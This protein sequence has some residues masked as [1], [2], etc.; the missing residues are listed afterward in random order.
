MNL[1]SSMVSLPPKGSSY[2]A[3]KGTGLKH[4]L[5]SCVQTKQPKKFFLSSLKAHSTVLLEGLYPLLVFNVLCLT[6][7]LYSARLY[8]MAHQFKSRPPNDS[9]ISTYFLQTAFRPRTLELENPSG[10]SYGMS[11]FLIQHKPFYEGFV[12]QSFLR[13]L[14]CIKSCP[15]ISQMKDT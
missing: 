5:L 10:I 13:T 14:V 15:A 3:S 8:Q 12:V 4:T 2:L 6:L 1:M 7:L 9:I 11:Q